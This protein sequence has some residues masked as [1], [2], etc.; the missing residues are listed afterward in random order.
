[1]MGLV[2]WSVTVTVVGFSATAGD[3]FIFFSAAVKCSTFT[4]VKISTIAFKEPKSPTVTTANWS[5]R[6]QS[7]ESL[8]CDIFEI[9]HIDLHDRLMRQVARPVQPALASLRSLAEDHP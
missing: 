4:S 6:D 8:T 1:M 2:S 9:G 5:N 7:T 3:I